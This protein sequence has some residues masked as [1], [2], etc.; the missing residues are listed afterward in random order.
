MN[1]ISYSTVSFPNL[2]YDKQVILKSTAHTMYVNSITVC[3]ISSN[4]IRINLI[5]K[6]IG[7]DLSIKE[8]FLVK[9][10]VG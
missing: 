1:F 8:T 5:K 3:N 10:I 4:D 6:I 9:N 7:S 2:T